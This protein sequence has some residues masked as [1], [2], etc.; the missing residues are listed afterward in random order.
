M[1][2][3]VKYRF[4]CKCFLYS[5]PTICTCINSSYVYVY[6][7]GSSCVLYSSYYCSWEVWF[8]FSWSIFFI[9]L[10]RV[11]TSIIFVT[12]FLPSC[13]FCS[14][15]STAVFR[16][17]FFISTGSP[18]AFSS[19]LC[20]YPSSWCSFNSVVKVSQLVIVNCPANSSSTLSSA[21]HVVNWLCIYSFS[22][23]SSYIEL[24]C[25]ALSSFI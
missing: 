11:S 9:V 20:K 7:H 4:I 24:S 12:I 17:T 8:C 19:S 5:F 23:A 14:I 18:V 3:T 15:H 1:L 16:I 25:M 13:G 6:T 10:S 21:H 22:Y 2:A